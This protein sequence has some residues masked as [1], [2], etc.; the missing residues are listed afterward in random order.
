MN[1][2]S[3][4]TL[5]NLADGLLSPAE[6]PTIEEHLRG[7]PACRRLAAE[8]QAFSDA[9]RSLPLATPSEEFETAV[10]DAVLRP[11]RTRGRET[12]R[13]RQY[14]WILLLC[15]M[16][17]GILFLAASGEDDSA[18]WMAPLQ[19]WAGTQLRPLAQRIGEGYRQAVAPMQQ[20]GRQGS[21]VFEILSLAL[22]GLGALYAVD[23]FLLPRLRR[24]SA[25]TPRQ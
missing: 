24:P 1:H 22:L 6:R 2:P 15:L 19:E 17:L 10:L 16:T 14:A 13:L 9:L 18:S 4:N 8:E 20:S 12:P 7:C 25:R 11:E 23:Q 3:R 5:R 21:N